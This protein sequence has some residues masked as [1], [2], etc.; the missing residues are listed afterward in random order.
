[1]FTCYRAHNHVCGGVTIG[2]SLLRVD[3]HNDMSQCSTVK[4]NKGGSK[5]SIHYLTI[6]PFELFF[7]LTFGCGTICAEVVIVVLH[8]NFHYLAYSYIAFKLLG[9]TFL[10]ESLLI[11]PRALWLYPIQYIN[12]V[13]SFWQRF[14]TLLKYNMKHCW[15][16]LLI[17]QPT[18]TCISGIIS[19]R[20]KTFKNLVKTKDRCIKYAELCYDIASCVASG[21]IWSSAVWRD[22]CLRQTPERSEGP[23]NHSTYYWGQPKMSSASWWRWAHSDLFAANKCTLQIILI[24]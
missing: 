16:N 24:L 22:I 13:D 21:Y 5:D 7:R 4:I 8:C 11:L 3:M 20:A 9:I 2:T 19:S 1:M 17:K 12:V 18:Q 10:K 6:P 15:Y 23:Q 14:P